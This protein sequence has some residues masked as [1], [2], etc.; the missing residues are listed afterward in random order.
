MNL[1]VVLLDLFALIS[2]SK[3]SSAEGL[4]EVLMAEVAL[5]NAQIDIMMEEIRRLSK[6]VD[7]IQLQR[8]G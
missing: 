5:L 4:S 2:E 6:I 1:Y 8:E 3:R 7:K